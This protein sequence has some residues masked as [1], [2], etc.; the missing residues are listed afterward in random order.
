M[1]KTSPKPKPNSPRNE[2]IPSD[3]AL[4]ERNQKLGSNKDEQWQLLSVAIDAADISMVVTDPRREDNPI[5]YVNRGFT[6]LSGYSK[7]ECLDR[8]C[9]F[10]NAEDSNQLGLTVVRRA[11]EQGESAKVLLRN[12]R[13][14]GE[15]FW[16]E[17][18]LSPVY[19]EGKLVL[20]LGVQNDVSERVSHETNLQ[21]AIEKTFEDSGWFTSAVMDNLINIRGDHVGT[22]SVD[23]L[24]ARERQTL[25]LIAAGLK[26]NDIAER[27]NIT[28]NT[29]RNYVASIYDK[30][31][32]HS[33]TDAA[34]W[35][36]ERGLI[37]E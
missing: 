30:I 31:G 19:D 32:V 1:D 16:N 13:K 36:R 9:R 25:E 15:M 14:N 22:G 29:V 3:E 26:N 18:Y 35:A 7:E 2:D 28:V 20:F 27:L 17:L 4:L 12:Y 10:M 24:T 6:E 21:E 33:R 5:I 37:A 34:I 8:N 23:E 11:V